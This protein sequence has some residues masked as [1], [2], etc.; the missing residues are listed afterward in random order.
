M[1]EKLTRHQILL[2]AGDMDRLK[3][4]W[5]NR[6]PTSVIR[7][8]VRQHCDRVETKLMEQGDGRNLKLSKL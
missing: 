3:A 4:I 8:L 7:D 5:H 6:S 2:Y 1:S